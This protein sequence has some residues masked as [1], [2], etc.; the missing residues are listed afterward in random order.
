MSLRH[1]WR[2]ADPSYVSSESQT[3]AMLGIFGKD[4]ERFRANIDMRN[5]GEE[6]FEFDMITNQIKRFE[7]GWEWQDFKGS[8][9][10]FQR[11][12]L[13]PF[14]NHIPNAVA[15][16][17][18]ANFYNPDYSVLYWKR[19]KNGLELINKLVEVKGTRNIK[20][21][22]YDIYVNYQKNVINPHNDKVRKY[23]KDH[24]VPKCLVEFELFLYPD[25]YATGFKA[26]KDNTTWNPTIHHLEKLEIYT[27]DELEAIWNKTPRTD[28]QNVRLR[29][30]TKSIFD[31]KKVNAIDGI[32][33]WSDDHYKKAIHRSALNNY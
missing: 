13:D 23:A 10:S 7:R 31:P 26:N 6:I 8:V 3:K 21:Q 12:G 28:H 32:T 9:G 20:N 11:F 30:H 33:N 2:I 22:D 29:K 18:D 17:H 14:E 24:F 27:V 4:H 1:L 19:T 16:T 5:F 25:A 15:F